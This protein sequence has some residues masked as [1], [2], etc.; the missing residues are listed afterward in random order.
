MSAFPLIATVQRTLRLV[1]FV[2]GRDIASRLR[3]PQR[4]TGRQ[5]TSE[6]GLVLGATQRSLSHMILQDIR[7]F[8]VNLLPDV[9]RS[10]CDLEP[11]AKSCP[12][13]VS[14]PHAMLE[15]P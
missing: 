3:R 11:P 4:L 13:A 6:S 10:M 2:P 7:T 14:K 8:V 5:R 12:E 9:A 1:R 15:V